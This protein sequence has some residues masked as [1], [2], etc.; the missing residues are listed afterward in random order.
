MPIHP[1]RPAEFVVYTV[2]MAALT[3]GM[4]I[5]WWRS[6]ERGRGPYLPLLLLAGML[7]AVCEPVFDNLVLFWYPS[8]QQLWAF[9]AFGRTVPICVVI[10]YGWFD[11][12]LLYL[13]ARLLERGIGR[14][15]LWRLAGIVYLVD[16]LAI[17]LTSWLKIAGFYGHPPFSVLGYPLWWGA[18]DTANVIFGGAVL[19]YLL[20]RVAGRRRVYLLALPTWITGMTAV[21][22]G[23]PVA[24]A[25][26]SQWSMAGKVAMALVTV[27][28]GL[29]MVD[30]VISRVGAVEEAPALTGGTSTAVAEV[31]QDGL[32]AEPAREPRDA[33]AGAAAG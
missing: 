25:V 23:G 21:A 5:W 14:R 6:S 24:I 16:F 15:G 27:G 26:N 29:G 7:S 11:G 10:G 22:I 32:R 13:T 9:H 17:G 30:L 31:A 2:L 4:L 3:G 33:P 28:L 20:P 19:Y 8:H 18:I 1:D 12:G